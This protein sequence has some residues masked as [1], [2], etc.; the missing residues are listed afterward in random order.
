MAEKCG[1]PVVIKPAPKN[2]IFM[3]AASAAVFGAVSFLLFGI[4]ESL[5][6]Y[7]CGGAHVLSFAVLTAVIIAAAGTALPIAEMVFTQELEITEKE[8]IYR[9][10]L[11]TKKTMTVS[12]N[13]M[14]SV[15]VSQ[16][17]CQLL[18]G[19]GDITVIS[20]GYAVIRM[21]GVASPSAVA[22]EYLGARGAAASEQH[23]DMRPGDQDG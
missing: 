4:S 19:T 8:V 15:E 5:G 10:G 21:R 9:K 18:A 2:F 1:K 7:F 13:F 11:I 12:R 23:T 22:A 16:T 17:P 14:L 3:S 20:G 6:A